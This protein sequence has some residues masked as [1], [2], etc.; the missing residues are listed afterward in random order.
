MMTSE[1]QQNAMQA[2][3]VSNALAA[4]QVGDAAAPAAH[5]SS[6]RTTSS[7]PPIKQVDINC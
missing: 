3:L 4:Q 2:T 7:S 1:Q 5:P 6:G